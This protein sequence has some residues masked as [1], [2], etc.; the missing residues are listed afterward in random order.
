MFYPKIRQYPKFNS[1]CV[2]PTSGFPEFTMQVGVVL[3]D[4]F[5]RDFASTRLENL[6][7][8]SNAR[9]NFRFRTICHK[10]SLAALVVCWRLA[11]SDI[12]VKPTVT[13]V[14]WLRWRLAIQS[15][16]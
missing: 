2:A 1:V 15:R 14:V 13:C 12:T 16:E 8:F 9:D 11:E 4:F 5:L 10:Q 7:N 6:H 3:R